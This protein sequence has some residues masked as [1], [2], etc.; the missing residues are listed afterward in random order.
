MVFGKCS[1]SLIVYSEFFTD[2]I[3]CLS[4]HFLTLYNELVA[5]VKFFGSV[6]STTPFN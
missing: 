6:V 4:S 1:C 5:K 2:N 3:D